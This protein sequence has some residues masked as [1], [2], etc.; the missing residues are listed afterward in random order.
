MRGRRVAR[1]AKRPP[2]AAN[3]EADFVNRKNVKKSA[4][5]AR[6]LRSAKLGGGHSSSMRAGTAWYN[7]Q[8]E[9][10]KWFSC[11]DPLF[12]AV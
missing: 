4:L 5:F 11:L 9:R 6:D 12:D 3:G 8:S 1:I 10:K 2:E 7:G